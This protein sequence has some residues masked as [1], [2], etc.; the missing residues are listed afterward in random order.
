M[1]IRPRLFLTDIQKINGSSGF[2]MVNPGDV[3][4]AQGIGD[5]T[6]EARVVRKNRF[7]V[8]R[9]DPVHRCFLHSEEIYRAQ[10]LLDSN[11]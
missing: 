10:Q 2:R 3:I 1:K 11:C 8:I 7:F 6:A 4:S 5:C 9:I